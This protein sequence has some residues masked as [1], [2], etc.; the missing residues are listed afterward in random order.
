MHKRVSWRQPE[1]HRI[2][3]IRERGREGRREGGREERYG[4]Q[5]GVVARDF[6]ASNEHFG[7]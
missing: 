5:L 3:N 2:D 6:I 1:A 7:D 4:G